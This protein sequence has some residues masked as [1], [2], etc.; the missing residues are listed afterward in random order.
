[1]IIHG[2]C[3][4][5]GGAIYRLG[6]LLLELDDPKRVIARSRAAI[7]SPK[8]PYERIGDVPNVVFTSGAIADPDG[9]VRIYYGAADTCM[10]VA[11]ASLDDLVNACF[12]R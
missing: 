4:T 1:M 3:T 9:T 7:L 12:E 8:E 10:C 5:A 6:V 11:T 2:A